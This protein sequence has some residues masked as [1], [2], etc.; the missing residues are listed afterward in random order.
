[1]KQLQEVKHT[2]NYTFP[3]PPPSFIYA[4]L[5]VITEKQSYK[6]TSVSQAT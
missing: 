6:A 3:I 4:A 2:W 5:K 1:M